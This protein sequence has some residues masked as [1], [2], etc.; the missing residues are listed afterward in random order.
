MV[1]HPAQA[2]QPGRAPGDPRYAIDIR[3]FVVVIVSAMAIAFGVGVGMGPTAEQL[4][5]SSLPQVTSVYTDPEIVNTEDLH[6]P[7]GQVRK[8]HDTR[9]I[10]LLMS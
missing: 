6:E 9:M 5:A 10:V 2:A 8:E 1:E 4:M 3:V 7:A